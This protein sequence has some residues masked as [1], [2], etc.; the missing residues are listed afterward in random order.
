MKRGLFVLAV[1][2]AI[3]IAGGVL[4]AG[5]GFEIPIIQQVDSPAASAFEATPNQAVTFLLVVGFILV[6]VVGAG[7]TLAF[8]FWLLNREVNRAKAMPTLEERREQDAE[9]LPETA[10]DAA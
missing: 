8:I 2:V 3:T 4:T 7:L 9:S 5:V 10:T 1:L 6:N